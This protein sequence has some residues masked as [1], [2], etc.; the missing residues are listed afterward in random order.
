MGHRVVAVEPTIELR[1]RAARLHPSDNIEWLDDSLPALARLMGRGDSFDIVMLTAVWTHFDLPQR[2]Q[3]MPNVGRLVRK[4]GIMVMSLR[5]GPV[6]P[7]RRMFDVSA[8]E[9]IQLADPESLTPVLKVED[10]D[11]MLGRPGVSWTC[12]AFS[13]VAGA[14]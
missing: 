10:R 2:R 8:E 11:S 1:T 7:G 13:K 6:P 3:A 12:L 4:G 14:M 9:T 5:H